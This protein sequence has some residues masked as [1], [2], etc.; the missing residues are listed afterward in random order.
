MEGFDLATVGLTF[1]P[2]GLVAGATAGARATDA[3]GA[4]AGAT[5]SQM[6][7]LTMVFSSM[8]MNAAGVNPIVT[9]MLSLFARMRGSIGVLLGVGAALTAVT[10]V[11]RAIT[12][13]QRK[14]TDSTDALIKKYKEQRAAE[15]G[16]FDDA[17]KLRQ[18][19]EAERRSVEL[20]QGP[21]SAPV[22]PKGQV[23]GAGI[24]SHYE[25]TGAEQFTA[26]L[27]ALKVHLADVVDWHG[28]LATFGI[29]KLNLSTMLVNAG[30]KKQQEILIAITDAEKA[31]AEERKKT[32]A[33]FAGTAVAAYQA[34]VGGRGTAE[35]LLRKL[36]AEARVPA[37]MREMRG[38][39]PGQIEAEALNIKRLRE[40]LAGITEQGQRQRAIEDQINQA[41]LARVSYE[42]RAIEARSKGLDFAKEEAALRAAEAKEEEAIAR[43]AATTRARTLRDAIHL[44]KEEKDRLGW[45]LEIN[46]AAAAGARELE[47]QLNAE[48][49]LAA[50]RERQT[51]HAEQRWERERVAAQANLLARSRGLPGGWK[52]EK[53]AMYVGLGRWMTAP[54]YIEAVARGRQV[55]GATDVEYDDMLK[56]L[57]EERAE[58][59]RNIWADAFSAVF[60]HGLKGW[61]AFFGVVIQYASRA[62]AAIAAEMARIDAFNETPA[63]I[64]K[65]MTA[66]WGRKELGQALGGAGAGLGV[67]AATRNPFV[68]AVGGA[69]AGFAAGG[70]LGA[71]AGAIAG[72]VSGM[73]G[74]SAAAKEAADRLR[75]AEMAWKS[76]FADFVAIAKPQGPLGSGLKQLEDQF[77]ALAEAAAR[78]HDITLLTDA[79]R[80]MSLLERERAVILKDLARAQRVGDEDLA[81]FLLKLLDLRDVYEASAEAIRALIAL[82]KRRMT[83]DLEVRR[84]RA[85]GD[86]AGAEALSFRLAQEREYYELEKQMG[87]ERDES[88]LALLAEVQALE[89]VTEARRAEMEVARKAMD[90]HRTDLS[91]AER[92]AG[93]TGDPAAVARARYASEMADVERQLFEKSLTREQAARLAAVVTGELAKALED[94][95]KQAA[96]AEAAIV[97]YNAGLVA[98]LAVRQL[99][100]QAVIS[101]RSEDARLA[102]EARVALEQERE[103]EAALKNN[104][105]EAT[106]EFIKLTH[107]LEDQA[108]AAE[109]LNRIE[110]ERIR[111]LEQ[112]RSLLQDLD[113]RWL[114]A[115][116][117]EEA[118]AELQADVDRRRQIANAQ[119]LKLGQDTIDY[120]NRI[121]DAE[122]TRRESDRQAAQQS[123]FER[124]LAQAT[125]TTEALTSTPASV[126]FGASV[127]YDQGQHMIS[128]L[129][130][131]LQVQERTATAT[132]TIAH[133]PRVSLGEID[134]GLGIAGARTDRNKGVLPSV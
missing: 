1:D 30:L 71:A 50:E 56:S 51:A 9:Q 26:T 53:D 4:A 7:R 47:R 78:Q 98:D 66:P 86:D 82:E 64:L 72:F 34:G 109:E 121:F 45:M 41:L 92:E 75:L 25:R 120:I 42:R 116:G 105:T 23:V 11:Y 114:R 131:S 119:E 77:T 126:N 128:L 123:A 36:E 79:E 20:L 37:L 134:I 96:E 93:L 80:G 125:S 40:A 69:G 14:L 58:T 57:N 129:I 55:M 62:A 90:A 133:S 39:K 102:R 33:E 19:L 32:V 118:A 115:I 27:K 63:G 49:R 95:A 106:I 127:S 17:H 84:L 94:I 122:R 8:A 13:E 91:I 99:E 3:L 97:E 31:L 130:S 68:G 104:A 16:V 24:W 117:Q 88:L 67:G 65:P 35:A 60:T 6:R 113:V 100:A 101:G 46:D 74:S 28:R 83:E 107:A 108:R 5:A 81:A 44:G 89:A 76:G 110:E 103:I 70:P 61:D 59:F 111:L 43:I 87:D 38:D 2:S 15:R 10:I 29:V 73:L 22:V 12:A 18:R 54:E 132:E 112:Q 124:A 52:G 21:P 48:A 85:T